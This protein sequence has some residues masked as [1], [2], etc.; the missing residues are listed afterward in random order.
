MTDQWEDKRFRPI[1]GK[2]GW[3]IADTNK[4]GRTSP[5]TVPALATAELACI[6]L[7]VGRADAAQRLLEERASLYDWSAL[8]RLRNYEAIREDEKRAADRERR[9]ET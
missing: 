7:E 1:L 9:D 4:G 8:E 2:D 5:G 3:H 6:L